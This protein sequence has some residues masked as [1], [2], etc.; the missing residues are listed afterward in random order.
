MLR[1]QKPWTRARSARKGYNEVSVCP[2]CAR[3]PCMPGGIQWRGRVGRFCLVC[4]LFWRHVCRLPDNN[5]IELGTEVFEAP[6]VLFNPEIIGL[7]YAGVPQTLV[8]SIQKS[9]LD[10]RKTL[11]GSI[12]LSGGE[13]GCCL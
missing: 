7:E 11:Y 9:D 5:E 3:S 2:A 4:V 10:I 12:T 8:N 1:G 6:E 13:R